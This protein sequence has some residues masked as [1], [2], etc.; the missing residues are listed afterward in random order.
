M[1]AAALARGPSVREAKG[2]GSG[3]RLVRWGPRPRLRVYVEAA[4]YGVLRSERRMRIPIRG[5]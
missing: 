1:G 2:S 3:A 4:V 5:Q